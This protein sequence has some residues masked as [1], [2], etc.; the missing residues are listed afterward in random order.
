MSAPTG[1]LKF[2]HDTI[3]NLEQEIATLRAQLAASEARAER[4]A[5]ALA[6]LE[7]KIFT[8]K[9]GGRAKLT[10]AGQNLLDAMEWLT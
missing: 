3:A 6:W 9:W 4:L 10:E 5:K 2:A 7:R 1:K 8:R